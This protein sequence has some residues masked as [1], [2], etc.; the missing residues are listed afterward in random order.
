MSFGISAQDIHYSQFNHAP[1]L[2]NPALTGLFDGEH[3][4]MANYRAQ[5]NTVPVGYKTFSGVYDT[6]AFRQEDGKSFFGFGGIFNFDEA[7]DS[8]LGTINLGASASYSH[9]ILKSSWLTAGVQL[10]GYQRR[11]QTQDLRT[12]NQWDSGEDRYDPSRSLG[13]NFDNQSIVYGDIGAG[14]NWRYQKP[15]SRTSLDVGVAMHHINQPNKSFMNDVDDKLPNRK[16]WYGIASLQATSTVDIVLNLVGNYQG[17]YVEHLLGL[18][19]RLHLSQKR[20][21]ELSMLLGFNYRFNDGFGFDDAIYPTVVVEYQSWRVGLSYDLDIST[22]SNPTSGNGGP[23]ISL[24]YLFKN[25]GKP[26]FCPTC[27]TYL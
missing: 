14:V 21:K 7:G 17:P 22:F 2:L 11:F 24:R 27:P 20:T 26:D 18:A 4:V 5:W 10:M 23:E 3:R 1:L 6:K 12:D 25:V 13:E 9:Q 16:T 19:G 15:T 8:H